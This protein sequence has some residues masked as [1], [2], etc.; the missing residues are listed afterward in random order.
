MEVHVDDYSRA[1][2]IKGA[3]RSEEEKGSAWVNVFA[4]VIWL[5]AGAVAFIPFAFDTSP[6]TL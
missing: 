2:S 5:L 3:A 1:A 4:L 6:G